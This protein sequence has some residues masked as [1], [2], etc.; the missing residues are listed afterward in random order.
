[1]VT[2][3]TKGQ[4]IRKKK[5]RRDYL[6]ELKKREEEGRGKR[7]ERERVL[8]KGK[9]V[10]EEDGA[11]ARLVPSSSDI[12]YWWGVKLIKLKLKLIINPEFPE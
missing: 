3:L 1:M 6:G 7:E 2:N 12:H 5:Q 11:T 4:S 10:L 9:G 8:E